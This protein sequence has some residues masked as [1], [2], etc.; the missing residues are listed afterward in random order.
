VRIHSGRPVFDREVTLASNGN[1]ATTGVPLRAELTFTLVRDGKPLVERPVRPLYAAGDVVI[2][3]GG[4]ATPE[5]ADA[6][7]FALN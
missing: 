3:F 4:P 7:G 1:Y 5:D 6:P 2:N